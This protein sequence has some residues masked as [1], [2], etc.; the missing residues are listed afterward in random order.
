MPI[1]K[2]DILTI[3]G[4]T[5]DIIFY[6]D[7]GQVANNKK[8]PTR[9]RLV[10]FEQG[11]KINIEE[12][13]FSTGGGACNTAVAFSRLGLKTITI[14]CIGDDKEGE[15][16]KEDLKTEGVDTSFVQVN[17][18]G[19]TGF[20][21]IAITRSHEQEHA[22]FLYRGANNGLD[23]SKD[24]LKK[25]N[26]K[27]VYLSSL[28]GADWQSILKTI[29]SYVQKS[30]FPP[31]GWRKRSGTKL[32]WNP[33]STQLEG[34]KKI[35]DK[36]LRLTDVLILNQD[37]AIELVLSDKTIGKPN[38][39]IKKAEYLLETIYGWGVGMVVITAGEKGVYA[40]D[41][42]KLYHKRA[43]KTKAVDTTGAGD[44]FGS[45]FIAG[46]HLYNNIEKALKLALINSASVVAEIGTQKG[47]LRL[48]DIK[49][50]GSN[51]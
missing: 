45:S 36:F 2:L 49:K 21:F 4:A 15:K 26:S 32:A 39:H 34:G 28:T 51:L 22:A 11:A 20:S 44:A 12:A 40:Y 9:Q 47:L 17:K 29:I 43:R 50:L 16:V 5:R 41:G 19:A 3:G 13:Y 31:G 35:L 42:D 38:S 27:W 46:L 37:E 33:G 7:E 24:D 6:T 14:A 18:D 48:S 10:C 8:D 30:K 25:A 1:K 23:I